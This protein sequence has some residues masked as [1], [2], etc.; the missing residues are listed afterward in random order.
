MQMEQQ[1]KTPPKFQ[2]DL[3][4]IY[5][6]LTTR[7]YQLRSM[8]V[9]PCLTFLFHTLHSTVTIH[10]QAQQAQHCIVSNI[11]IIN[12][13]FKSSHQ[14]NS[15]RRFRY[16]IPE[17]LNKPITITRGMHIQNSSPSQTPAVTVHEEDQWKCRCWTEQHV[18]QHPHLQY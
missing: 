17:L 3:I 8:S 5:G 9:S 11:N 18:S 13:I 1:N 7:L 16:L 2:G 4:S 15:S 6:S 14:H 10:A 12:L